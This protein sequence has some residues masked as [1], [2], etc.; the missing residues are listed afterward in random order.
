MPHNFTD[1]YNI[2][3]GRPYIEVS[4][5]TGYYQFRRKYES[6]DSSAA[7]A[8]GSGITY[9]YSWSIS[10]NRLRGTYPTGGRMGMCLILEKTRTARFSPYVPYSWPPISMDMPA[11][12]YPTLLSNRHISAVSNTENYVTAKADS[13]VFSWTVNMA[14][15]QTIN[16]THPPSGFSSDLQGVVA[17]VQNTESAFQTY[18]GS[19]TDKPNQNQ[20]IGQRYAVRPTTIT[21]DLPSEVLGSA[22]AA[23]SELTPMGIFWPYGADVPKSSNTFDKNRTLPE[24][25][26]W[27]EINIYPIGFNSSYGLIYVGNFPVSHR[28]SYANQ[29]DPVSKIY[30][31]NTGS[32]D[33]ELHEFDDFIYW[34]TREGPIDF[35]SN[36]TKTSFTRDRRVLTLLYG[37][38]KDTPLEQSFDNRYHSLPGTLVTSNSIS[39]R[40]VGDID[41]PL[42]PYAMAFGGMY[43]NLHTELGMVTKG[44]PA[45][46]SSTISPMSE[47]LNSYSVPGAMCGNMIVDG[48]MWKRSFTAGVTQ[49]YMWAETGRVFRYEAPFGIPTGVSLTLVG[50][51]AT[52]AAMSDQAVSS[53]VNM[54]FPIYLG[55]ISTSVVH[56]NTMPEIGVCLGLHRGHHTIYLMESGITEVILI[57]KGTKGGDE[58][59]PKDLN[60]FDIVDPTP[61]YSYYGYGA[62][63]HHITFSKDGRLLIPTDIG[64]LEYDYMN[65]AVIGEWLNPTL[66]PFI[67]DMLT[68]DQS[69]KKFSMSYSVD[70]ITIN[71]EKKLYRKVSVTSTG[72]T[73]PVSINAESVYSRISHIGSYGQVCY[74]DA[75][76]SKDLFIKLTR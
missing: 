59:A 32:H 33:T 27:R 62:S 44:A 69:E 18:T 55:S 63:P 71:G 6:G 4:P 22:S 57:E 35:V 58:K 36:E 41:E 39:P 42:L 50:A 51:M 23:L 68:L 65:R 54:K 5:Y 11:W 14:K 64:I 28:I 43:D 10:K 76:F 61:I 40:Q 75:D 37:V 13:L 34:V 30:A 25:E 74:E 56:N 52:V 8:T 66:M 48:N 72:A 38:S 3:K 45:D 53:Y 70:T 1:S 21:P 20:N 47:I 26:S 60:V 7:W 9:Y 12:P 19:T 31:T 67:S 29:G 24:V 16:D 73:T 46:P 2:Y 17:Y 15:V 49:A